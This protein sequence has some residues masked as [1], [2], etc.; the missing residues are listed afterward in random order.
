MRQQ[1]ARA[2]QCVEVGGKG[3]RLRRDGTTASMTNVYTPTGKD[4]YTWQTTDRVVAGE[5]LPPMEIKVF[6]KPLEAAQS[7]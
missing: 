6:R 3:H 2:R 7:K 5:V 4:S 1:T